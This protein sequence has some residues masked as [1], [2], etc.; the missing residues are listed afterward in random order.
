MTMNFLKKYAGI[1]LLLIL[2]GGAYMFPRSSVP[3]PSYGGTFTP[4]QAQKFTLSGA[5]VTATANT[6][7][8]NNLLLSDGIT[9]I[10]MSMLGSIGYATIEPGTSKE[11]NISFT[12]ITQNSNSTATLTGVS[13]GLAFTAPYA[14]S[15]TLA[16]AHAG[17]TYIIFSNSAPFY[18]QFGILGNAQTW[19]GI[20]TF[21]S[22]TPPRYDYVGVQ[23][24][25]TYIAT[26][27]EFASVAYVNATALA[28]APNGTTGVKGVYQTATGLQA[29][30]STA[31][32]STGAS[33]SL[34]SANA[35][36]TPQYGCATGYTGIAGAGCSVIADLTGH[37]KQ[38]WLDLTKTFNFSGLVTMSGG[39]SVTA[40][41]TFSGN[42]TT[43]FSGG[44]AGINNYTDFTTSGTW[45]PPANITGNE[46]VYVQV[47]GGGGGGGN[48]TSSASTCGSGGGGGG[49]YTEGHFPLS[50]LGSSVSVTVASSVTASTTGNN[51]SFGSF[52]TAYGGG[53]GS[54]Q[55]NAGA[56]GG[57]GGGGN[58]SAGGYG[59]TSTGGVGG[60]FGGG[61]ASSNSSTGFG[62]AGGSNSAGGLASVYGGGSG[63]GNTG[64]NSS[65]G[66][67]SIYGG[68]GGA[69]GNAAG[70]VSNVGGSGG[71][72]CNTNGCTASSGNAP[73]GGG[74]GC[75]I[76]ASS[77]CN[78]G[79]G[80][81]GE[82]RVWIIR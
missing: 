80:A 64:S 5:G 9:P 11:E 24:N 37:I 79:G 43:T 50:I 32:G 57:G 69:S 30:S 7:I 70:G 68:G 74:G 16:Y 18:S 26:T 61:A 60:G 10:T 19:T 2:I 4:I 38:A 36:D 76:G 31:I 34:T 63:A 3:R 41:S 13:R 81:R 73:G 77:S 67:T 46:E 59:V 49:G 75:Q 1:A 51:S 52:L 28:G 8:V 15:T 47:W 35:T 29:A 44:L 40:S 20:D 25:G 39:L 55:G 42:A 54:T 6:V 22:T 82:V 17:G 78:G 21:G 45:T 58:T 33:L 27:S 72:G 62:G 12:G 71:D 53:A 23:A 48:C 66:G 65:T 14:A 56:G